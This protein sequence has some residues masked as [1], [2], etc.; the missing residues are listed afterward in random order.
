[1]DMIPSFCHIIKGYCP[2]TGFFGPILH[3][4]VE[5]SKKT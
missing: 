5:Y 1:M 2:V 4:L 3:I